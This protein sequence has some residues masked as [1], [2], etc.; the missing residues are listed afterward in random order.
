M[1]TMANITVKAANNTTD[2]VYTGKSPSA[3]DTV[4][5]IW[6]N[7]TVGTAAQ[8]MPEFRLA[9]RD[10]PN[11]QERRGRATY[12][13]PQI[14][15]DTTTTLTSVVNKAMAGADFTLPKGMKMTDINEFAAQFGNLFASALIK[16]C[17]AEGYSAT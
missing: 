12:V 11:S 15:T 17:V 10:S 8:H 14:A 4:P 2:V 3:G 1:P 6:R 13:Y 7:E 5:A 9:F 16:A